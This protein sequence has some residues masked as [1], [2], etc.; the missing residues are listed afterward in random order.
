MSFLPLTSV[1]RRANNLMP[2]ASSAAPL[3]FRLR[4]TLATMVYAASYESDYPGVVGLGG[5]WDPAQMGTGGT[6]DEANM[7]ANFTAGRYTVLGTNATD[8][9][10]PTA[11]EVLLEEIGG[12]PNSTNVG[13][14]G[15]YLGDYSLYDKN[16][17]VGN[18]L[19]TGVDITWYP[20][21]FNL[22]SN[23]GVGNTLGLVVG[24]PQNVDIYLNGVLV[25]VGNW[26]GATT[27]P[28]ASA[29]TGGV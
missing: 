2:A 19:E 16:A 7:R 12:L 10:T 4:T 3:R 9:T 26:G 22:V 1:N 15:V 28:M 8:G 14:V 20:G 5:S 24:A 13:A 6:V 11:W 17:L 21:G 23:V 25:G 27:R 29:G 18:A